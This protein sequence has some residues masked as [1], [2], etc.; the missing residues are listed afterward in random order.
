VTRDLDTTFK[1]KRSTCRGRGH[2]VVASHTTCYLCKGRYV[3]HRIFLYFWISVSR[4][5]EKSSFI[6]WVQCVT[7]KIGLDSSHITL[8]AAGK[9]KVYVVDYD[10]LLH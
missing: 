1:V 3:L 6:S 8:A 9:A 7:S 5:I 4:M 10:G 2:V